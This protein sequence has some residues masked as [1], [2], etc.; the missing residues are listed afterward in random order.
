MKVV[1][2]LKLSVGV[3]LFTAL[4]GSAQVKPIVEDKKA[5]DKCMTDHFPP[6]WTIA[7]SSVSKRAERVRCTEP[8]PQ[9]CDI[10]Q[11]IRGKNRAGLQCLADA[12]FDFNADAARVIITSGMWDEEILTFILENKRGI[13]L[14]AKDDSG[15]TSLY[16][17]TTILGGIMDRGRWFSWD[18]IYNAAEL[19]LKKGANPDSTWKDGRTSLM[20]QASSGRTRVL[21]LL[22]R[23]KADPNIRSDDGRTALMKAADDPDIINPLLNAGADIRIKDNQGKTAIVHAIE[24]CEP[25]KATILL[26]IDKS[27]LNSLDNSGRAPIYY[28]KSRTGPSA[29][30][31]KVKQVLSTFS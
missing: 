16:M 3:V 17:L 12:D 9:L 23:Y 20:F 13:D 31:K 1:V 7:A 2:L 26:K 22:L 24:N 19:L 28:L 4:V 30:C 11:G 10:Y 8:S 18:R 27:I 21:E 5:I 15:R 29:E 6:V 25:I 14:E